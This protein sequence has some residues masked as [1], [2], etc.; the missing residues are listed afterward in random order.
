MK[1]T[2]PGQASQRQLRVGEEIRHAL[3]DLFLQGVICD[4]ALSGVSITVSE[5]TVSPDL[6]HATA[7]VSPL[8][9][10]ATDDF[11]SLLNRAAPQLSHMVAGM[12]KMRFSPKIT[13]RRDNSFEIANNM[14]KLIDSVMKE[15]KGQKREREKEK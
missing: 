2:P 13:F 11:I 7:Y 15:E 12:I 5:V 8:G 10:E 1:K 6:K 9:K 4:P 14:E 3:S